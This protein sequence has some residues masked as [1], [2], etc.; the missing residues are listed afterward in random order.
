V[1][2]GV[3]VGVG[4]G[5]SVGASVGVGVGGA[6]G[7]TVGTTLGSCV[8]GSV[9]AVTVAVGT[10]TVGSG[11]TPT[12]GATGNEGVA[13]C[14]G[15]TGVFV[16]TANP[17]PGSGVSCG[18]PGASVGPSGFAVVTN[19]TGDRSMMVN[20]PRPF[21]LRAPFDP[22]ETSIVDLNFAPGAPLPLA[23]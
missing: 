3:G 8:G 15:A 2:C 7:I 16:P 17:I 4:A 13:D 20:G 21:A 22:K 19:F 11:V 14:S 10:T 1:G 18:E 12:V 6:V 9:G 5:V 23:T